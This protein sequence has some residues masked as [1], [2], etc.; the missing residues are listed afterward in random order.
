MCAAT[1]MP[2]SSRFLPENLVLSLRACANDCQIAPDVPIRHH[3]LG[4]KSDM[5][6]SV[7]TF[8]GIVAI[9]LG[10]LSLALR[11]SVKWF[12]AAIIVVFGALSV[13]SVYTDNDLLWGLESFPFGTPPP[14]GINFV[15]TIAFV[16][17]L[18][19]VGLMWFRAFIVREIDSQSRNIALVLALI[20]ITA[21]V[22]LVGMLQLWTLR[23]GG[24]TTATIFST[25]TWDVDSQSSSIRAVIC[26]LIGFPLQQWYAR[27]DPAIERNRWFVV[28]GGLIALG[29]L[30]MLGHTAYQPPTWLSHG[31]DFLHGVGASLWFGGLF[32]L[33]LFLKRAFRDRN[34]ALEAGR[35]LTTFSTWALYSVIMLA[36]SGGVI[37]VMV[38]DNVLDPTES[39]FATA[40]FIKLLIALIPIAL[41][42]YNRFRLMP[43]LRQD[44]ESAAAWSAL[45]KITMAE[46][47][48]LTVILLVTGRL[49]ISSSGLT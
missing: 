27:K 42:A 17:M 30:T 19:S 18:A 25:E 14:S 15:F 47:A 38:K 1:S 36:F 21:H 3:I 9:L 35:V 48:L 2:A 37:A 4:E 24:N 34:D 44:P 8:L 45:R 11:F 40:L 20:A 26:L 7:W 16:S 33:I 39:D 29:S 28:T 22:L 32:G 46:I 49:V 10:V 6:F 13:A 43:M 41:A 12:W 5:T 31:M 23:D